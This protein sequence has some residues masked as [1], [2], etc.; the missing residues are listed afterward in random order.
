MSG[1]SPTY[2]HLRCVV[3]LFGRQSDFRAPECDGDEW[4]SSG[5]MELLVKAGILGGTTYHGGP[6]LT[7]LGEGIYQQLVIGDDSPTLR[8]LAKHP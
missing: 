8:E 7:E 5:A 2:E 6:R 1:G 3:L 4:A